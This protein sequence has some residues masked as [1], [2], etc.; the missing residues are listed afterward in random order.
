MR[1]VEFWTLHSFVKVIM[2][3]C[4]KV[5]K[6][7]MFSCFSRGIITMDQFYYFEEKHDISEAEQASH[8]NFNAQLPIQSFH[9]WHTNLFLDICYSHKSHEFLCW[10]D[11]K[12]LLPLLGFVSVPHV[13]PRSLPWLHQHCGLHVGLWRAQQLSLQKFIAITLSIKGG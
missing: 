5:Y 4:I 10:W 12:C 9:N 13:H 2:C 7:L 6:N 1:A 8:S 3:T 11:P